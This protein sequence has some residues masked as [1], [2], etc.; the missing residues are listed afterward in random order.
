MIYLTP[1]SLILPKY[2]HV[3]GLFETL[4]SHHNLFKHGFTSWA[5]DNGRFP[6]LKLI[7]DGVKVNPKW[8]VEEWLKMLNFYPDDMRPL[9]RFMVVPDV[10]FDRQ[11]T[12]DIFDHYLPMVKERGY[13][14]A[15][16]TQD[17]VTSGEIP[18]SKIDALFIGGSDDHK[19]GRDAAALS[20]EAH[21]RGKWVHVGR[22]NSLRRIKHVWWADSVDGTMLAHNNGI[23]RQ[24]LLAEG[25]VYCRAKKS[26]RRLL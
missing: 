23:D 19:L 13:P 15:F 17:G 25:V 9:C 7:A 4:G 5:G 20:V 26:T 6:P 1:T 2:K 8:T 12:L 3:F 18:W 22:V 24:R 14:A 10:P 11:G 21:Q 16:V